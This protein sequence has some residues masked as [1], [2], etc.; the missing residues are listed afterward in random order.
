MENTIRSPSPPRT[1]IT[2]RRNP[3]RKAR[4]TPSTTAGAVPHLS[5]S[6]HRNRREIAP[7]RL[8]EI[9]D[10]NVPQIA[11]VA[12]AVAPPNP[13]EEDDISENLKVFLRIR[14]I[15]I[16]KLISKAGNNASRHKIKELSLKKETVAKN[17]KSKTKK[18]KEICLVV[19]DSRSVTLSPP[20]SLQESKRTQTVVYD[21]FSYVFAPGSLQEE[22]YGKVMEPLVS[23]FLR[24]KSGL[25]AALGPSGSGK[26]HTIFGCPREPGIVSLTLRRLFEK[27]SSEELSRSYTISVF[28]IY[29]ERGKGEKIFD[30][31][32][33]RADLCLQQS[34]IKG[35]RENMVSDVKEAECLIARA[36]LKRATAITNANTHSSRSQCII[37][38]YTFLKKIN[39]GEAEVQETEES[40][41]VLTIVDLAGAER[42]RKTGNQG[43]RL[44]ESNFINNTSMVFGLC[45][46]SLLE[47]QKN[48]K[49]PLQKHFQNSVLTR[50]L[51]DYLEG[52][53][54][55]T[56]ILTAKP[57]EDDYLDTAN[58]LRQ[59]SP[60][61]KIKFNDVEELSHLLG[62]KRHVQTLSK[63]E[64]PKRRKFGDRVVS[65]INAGEGVGDDL[66]I[67]KKEIILG[68]LQEPEDLNVSVSS[69]RPL[70]MECSECNLLKEEYRIE[71]AHR[72]RNDQ[73]MRSFSKALWDVLKQYKKKFEA[74]ETEVHS[75]K[76]G[77][78]KEKFR[79]SELEKELKDMK[80]CHSWCRQNS[81]EASTLKLCMDTGFNTT[82]C[83]QLEQHESNNIHEVHAEVCAAKPEVLE[84]SNT[85]N[86][87]DVVPK[88][89]EMS[90]Q[91]HAE[92]CAPKP[93]VLECSST[94]NLCD[95]VVSKSLKMSLQF[96]FE[97]KS[98]NV[99]V[100]RC[101][102]QESHSTPKKENNGE[103]S[104]EQENLEVKDSCSDAD[105]TGLSD[106]G[107]MVGTSQSQALVG[108]DNS[109]P[110]EQ[111]ELLGE[112]EKIPKSEV[113]HF[114][115]RPLDG[116]KP[117]R[118]LGPP[119]SSLLKD[120]SNFD[121]QDDDKR[122][123]SRGRRKS[124]AG[125]RSLTQGS[126]SL[127]KLLGNYRHL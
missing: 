2:V 107:S 117:R 108:N 27:N 21:G 32:S 48:P 67:L 54:R 68:Q 25:L 40:N 71:L 33:D 122:K 58:L 72:E 77:L 8:P 87:C 29:S 97:Y 91:V 65:V 83:L 30:L 119:P 94:S 35:L 16:S 127:L 39:D 41:A 50:Y 101:T 14:P 69:T 98:S 60:Y 70:K 49:K 116:E 89:L 12:E 43:A 7:F 95:V 45:L 93:E 52:K 9:L 80:P 26:T 104:E 96:S 17:D 59:A 3:L 105:I 44:L 78:Q 99:A 1:C 28:E 37:N 66:S 38:I 100:V 34:A 20:A 111:K 47:H 15:E 113:K 125:E 46:R 121:L 64:Q 57:G 10:D 84:C 120:V 61:M 110:M 18:K 124:M 24:G 74:S 118:R 123:G 126:I 36:M 88:S 63:I 55:M 114:P 102:N 23:D 76:E 19:K 103:Y 56:L 73:I 106:S 112:G 90:L 31:T 4:A 51:R 85:S 82:G 86:L 109:T 92:V 81:T 115:N 79:N 75:L 22:V 6:V 53:R 62:Q 11:S 5:S 42:E 13:L